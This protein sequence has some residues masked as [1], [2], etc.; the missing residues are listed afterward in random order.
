MALPNDPRYAQV[1]EPELYDFMGRFALKLTRDPS[2][3]DDVRKGAC[4][5]VSPPASA[6]QPT[7][8]LQF[9]VAKAE[10]LHLDC[11]YTN[12]TSETIAYGESTSQ[13]MCAFVIY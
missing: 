9:D 2:D 6:C 13:E 3:A 10:S 1:C 7:I 8:P 12:P 4:S 5:F 11:Q